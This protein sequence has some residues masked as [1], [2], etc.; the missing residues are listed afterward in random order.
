M[1]AK[2][3]HQTQTR[4]KM[5]TSALFR[6]LL[7]C[8]G[9]FNA[10]DKFHAKMRGAALSLWRRCNCTART[11]FLEP[12]PSAVMLSATKLLWRLAQGMRICSAHSQG[13]QDHGHSRM[14]VQALVD[15][16]ESDITSLAAMGGPTNQIWIS[17]HAG[18]VRQGRAASLISRVFVPTVPQTRTTPTTTTGCWGYGCSIRN[19]QASTSIAGSHCAPS[20]ISRSTSRSYLA[21]KHAPPTFSPA[22]PL[23]KNEKRI[24]RGS[25]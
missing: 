9:T 19:V 18:Q 1:R 10:S 22:S 15:K 21:R 20:G 11:W 6:E 16:M 14:V 7:H 3:A 25:S 23:D 13:T 24:L 2:C 12:Q 17:I 4:A 8:V 5:L